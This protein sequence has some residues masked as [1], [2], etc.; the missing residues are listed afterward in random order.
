MVKL[1]KL[2]RE[3]VNNKPFLIDQIFDLYGGVPGEF[4]SYEYNGEER[5]LY[6]DGLYCTIL[7]IEGEYIVYTSFMVDEDYDVS[8]MEFDEFSVAKN[9]NG[10]KLLYKEGTSIA[11]S[12]TMQKRKDSASLNDLD[13][14]ITHHLVNTK[15]GE[16]LLI[17]YKALYRENPDYYQS[18]F[19]R[20]FIF[21]FIKKGKVE[22]YMQYTTSTDYLSYDVITIKEF[23]LVEF[24]Q[25]GSYALQQE[26]SIT[27]YFKIKAQ[28]SDGRCVLLY[29]LS[30]AYTEEDM[31]KKI[32][33]KG[34]TRKIKDYVLDYYNGAYL[35]RAEYKDLALAMEEYDKS[36][37]DDK[38]LSKI[39]GEGNGNN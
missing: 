11:E 36:H 21:S 1:E 7:G 6:R 33:E 29:P 2:S 38:K 12:I 23:G 25:N 19:Y 18:L 17:T 9:Q 15:S 8:Y 31:D 20:P 35:E 32:E 3:E 26:R 37:S 30:R 24:M 16:E 28:L 14:L 39:V 10:E 13:G 4:Y 5:W 27:R 34:F 22:Q